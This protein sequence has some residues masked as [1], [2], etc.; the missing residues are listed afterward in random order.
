MEP[1]RSQSKEPDMLQSLKAL[2]GRKLGASDGDIG[3]VQDFYFDD[4]TWAVR[5]VI[6]DTGTWLPG[7][8]VLIAPHAFGSLHQDGKH[9]L[10]NL[11]RQRIEDSPLIET[12]KPVSRQFEE[13]YFQ[14]YGWPSY[15]QGGGIWGSGSLPIWLPPATPPP[16]EQSQAGGAEFPPEDAHLRSTRAVTGYHLEASNG[17]AGLVCDLLMDAQSWVVRQLVV[18]TGHWL[19]GTEARIPTSDVDRISFDESTVFVR[20]TK[21][22]VEENATQDVA[23]VGAAN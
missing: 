5:Y 22:A 20:S 21:E 23:S 6:A 12:H 2:Y 11:T 1:N 17:I 4:Q 18:K 16:S 13:E 7:R 9:L 19:S 8:Q 14:Y 15:W 10:V 3:H